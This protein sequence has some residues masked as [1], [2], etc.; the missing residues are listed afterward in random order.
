ME[1]KLIQTATTILQGIL[2]NMKFLESCSQKQLSWNT[3]TYRAFFLMEEQLLQ[4]ATIIL[5]GTLNNIRTPQSNSSISTKNTFLTEYLPLPAF[6]C[7][8][9]V[10]CKSYKFYEMISNKQF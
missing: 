5:Q 2:N 8:N 10:L 3:H 6:M 7:V 1:E 9:G 4:P